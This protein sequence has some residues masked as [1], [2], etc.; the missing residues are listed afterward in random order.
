MDRKHTFF[1][2]SIVTDTQYFVEV[3]R[4]PI[5]DKESKCKGGQRYNLVL[6]SDS[7]EKVGTTDKS[8]QGGSLLYCRIR[9]EVYAHIFRGRD[10][11]VRNLQCD[12]EVT[13][14]RDLVNSIKQ[15]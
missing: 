3:G 5:D 15:L 10:S 12:C 9:K 7:M 8:R 2:G 6:Y 11:G 13:I 4:H 14:K 1:C